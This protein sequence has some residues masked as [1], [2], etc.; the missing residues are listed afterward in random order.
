MPGPLSPSAFQRTAY[1]PGAIA[2]VNREKMPSL[3]PGRDAPGGG[4]GLQ[5]DPGREWAHATLG[6]DEGAVW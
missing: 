5:L 2:Q 6:L 1:L 4:A 3:V